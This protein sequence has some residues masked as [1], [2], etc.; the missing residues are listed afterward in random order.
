VITATIIT[1]SKVIQQNPTAK[2]HF[3]LKNVFLY[4]K[5]CLNSKKVVITLCKLSPFF[6]MSLVAFALAL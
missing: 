2:G 3:F 1:K 6:R 5:N 4:T